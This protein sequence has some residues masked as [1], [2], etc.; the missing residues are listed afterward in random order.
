MHDALGVRELQSS[1]RRQTHHERLRRSQ[2][3]TPVEHPTQAATVEVLGDQVQPA[4]GPP[5][6]HHDDV[7]VSEGSRRLHLLV[8]ALDET[9]FV[10]ERLRQELQRDATAQPDVVGQEDPAVRSGSERGDEA[11]AAADDTT[12]LIGQG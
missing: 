6:V 5:V 2:R 3:H 7:R 10:H 8:E 12:D 9:G 11:I 4:V 1:G